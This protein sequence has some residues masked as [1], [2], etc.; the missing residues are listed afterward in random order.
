M[1]IK[2]IFP[3][4]LGE[5]TVHGLHQWDY[6]RK[7]KVVAEGLPAQVE[8]HFACA[9]ME[10]A[11]VRFCEAKND[12]F[13]AAIPDQCL[14]QTT[15]I[16]AWVCEVGGTSGKTLLTVKL[17]I[18]T[19]TKPQPAPTVPEDVSDKY[20]EAVAAMNGLVE[21]FKSIKEDI[22]T[23]IKGEVVND[24]KKGEIIAQKAERDRNGN[25]FEEHYV[26][27]QDLTDGI[28]IAGKATEATK[29]SQ[30]AEGLELKNLMRYS[31]DGYTVYNEND[32]I[33]AGL[34]AIRVGSKT[35]SIGGTSVF[36]AETGPAGVGGVRYSPIYYDGNH[37]TFNWPARLAFTP[38]DNDTLFTITP[39]CYLADTGKVYSWGEHAESTKPTISYK[40]IVKYSNNNGGGEV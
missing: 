30:D 27:Q 3:P 16:R 26:S 28:A 31:E 36:I 34:L 21:D 2:A 24:L 11:V 25:I 4:G 6:G 15:P 1:S 8:I 39:E 17:P 40:Y 32:K 9:G 18:I 33:E 14:E 22:K 29:A 13:L 23:I 10:T 20:T 35:G 37:E 19:R 12:A 38:V 5:L 7:L